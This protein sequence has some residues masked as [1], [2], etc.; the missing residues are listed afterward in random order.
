MS[1][2][3][4]GFTGFVSFVC[5]ACSACSVCSRCTYWTD[6]LVWPFS[7]TSTHPNHTFV[8]VGM[9]VGTNVKTQKNPMDKKAPQKGSK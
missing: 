5:S 3:I 7:L 1:S 8:D 4:V 6:C 9:D 2:N